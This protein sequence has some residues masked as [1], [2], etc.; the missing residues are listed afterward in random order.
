MVVEAKVG[1]SLMDIA[2]EN[3]QMED[4]LTIARANDLPID[5]CCER[6]R[7]INVP[8]EVVSRKDLGRLSTG[9]NGESE[10]KWLLKGGEQQEE[11]CWV[12]S[13]FWRD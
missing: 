8:D 1:Q 12:D 3:S 11:G 5:Y 9:E 7:A 10:A 4:I 2:V 13:E 6:T